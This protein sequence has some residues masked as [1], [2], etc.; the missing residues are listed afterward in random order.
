MWLC[1]SG[2]RQAV[3]FRFGV[4]TYVTA[5]RYRKREPNS[6]RYFVCSWDRIDFFFIIPY[7]FSYFMDVFV[8]CRI[9]VL[10]VCVCGGDLE[11]T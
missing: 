5:T 9:L 10:L 8:L 1:P 3:N 7:F 11:G 6:V 2:D 4:Y